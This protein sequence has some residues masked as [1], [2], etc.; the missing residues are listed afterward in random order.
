LCPARLATQ[1]D[2]GSVLDARSSG[3]FDDELVAT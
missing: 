2:E 3:A 1:R